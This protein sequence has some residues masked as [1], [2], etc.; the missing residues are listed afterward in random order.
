MYL[1]DS[2]P[3]KLKSAIFPAKNTRMNRPPH[4]RA[5]PDLSAEILLLHSPGFRCSFPSLLGVVEPSGGS[6]KTQTFK[7]KQDMAGKN[8]A[9]VLSVLFVLMLACGSLS[10]QRMTYHATPPAHQVISPAIEHPSVPP[11]NVTFFSNLGTPT[12]LYYDL[13]GWVLAGP[14]NVT[15]GAAQWLAVPFT[16]SQSGHVTSVTAAIGSI[17]GTNSITVAVYNDDGTLANPGTLI[18]STTITTI[19]PF[20]TCCTATV[21]AHYMPTA[22]AVTAG[23]Q[24]W[25]VAE[26]T[27]AGTT[28]AGAWAFSTNS[29]VNFNLDDG[30]GWLGISDGGLA[31]S[32]KGT[33]P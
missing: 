29:L 3:R 10:A 17:G 19:Q 30:N 6:I 5:H 22:V 8:L 21:L 25:I 14:T 12:D 11:V 13:N 33:N 23:T 18:K 31:M 7:E 32:V 20:G 2:P 26:T 1:R 15:F 16:P 24:Y 4:R 28:F 9:R 27:N